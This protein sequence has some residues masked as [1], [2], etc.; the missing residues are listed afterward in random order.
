[1]QQLDKIKEIFRGAFIRN[2]ALLMSGTLLAQLVT[3]AITPLLSRLYLP[4]AFGLLGLL[5]A[6]VA[7][8]SGVSTLRYDMAIVLPKED[9]EAANLVVLSGAILTAVSFSSALVIALGGEQIAMRLGNEALQ[10]WLWWVPP[11]VLFTGLYQILTYWCTRQKKFQRLSISTVFA[12]LSSAGAKLGAGLLGA[13]PAGLIGGQIFG[14]CIAAL[15]LAVQVFRDDTAK[16]VDAF[17]RAKLRLLMARYGDF[18]RYN[19]PVTLMHA[20]RK[21]GP[22]IL[23]GW[24]FDPTI[25]GY[26]A[27]AFL[28]L[29]LP[30]ELITGALRQVYF[31]RASELYNQ[32]KAL[33]PNQRRA[34]LILMAIAVV[35]ASVFALIAPELFGLVLGAQ[36]IEAGHYAR[37]L[38]LYL[39]SSLIS[40][41]AMALVPVLNLQ[42]LLLFHQFI[43]LLGSAAA[44]VHGGLQNDPVLAI[45]LY[46]AVGASLNLVLIGVMIVQTRR[47]DRGEIKAYGGKS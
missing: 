42:R 31:Q 44:L 6:V 29:S 30:V 4:E 34:L 25:V 40:V 37:L 32:G 5:S 45:G 19:A 43:V 16:I 15:V 10:P 47:A 18:P 27:V 23:L 9:D 7:T 2:M 3:V 22:I 11:L 28:V 33:F 8:I 36:W 12:S 46:S 39:C 17:D 26:Y 20:L 35:P 21:H 1:M 14:Q 13:G 38:T 41:P 24:F